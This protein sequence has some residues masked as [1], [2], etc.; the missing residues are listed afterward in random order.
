MGHTEIHL[1]FSIGLTYLTWYG[2]IF[3]M[4]TFKAGKKN[5]K[6]TISD[7]KRETLIKYQ[8]EQFKILIKKGLS[9]PVA[10]L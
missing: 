7:Y 5:S 2:K 10:L 9:I 8:A 4:F 1:I 6:K 3:L